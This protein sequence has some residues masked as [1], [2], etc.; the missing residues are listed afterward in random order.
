MV[1][2]ILLE[3]YIASRI[4]AHASFKAAIC[5]A[6][7]LSNIVS[8]IIGIVIS[9]ILNGGW[10]LVCWFPWVSS[11]EVD[12]TGQALLALTLYY[13]CA[14]ILSVIIEGAINIAMLRHTYPTKQITRATLIVNIASYLAG[15][16]IMYTFSFS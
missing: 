9:M 4:L 1:L 13:I 15:T 2:I 7:I 16:I 12:L 11:H 8:G 3:C 10:W 5:K 6:V 14:F